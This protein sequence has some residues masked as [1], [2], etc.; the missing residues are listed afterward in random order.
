MP[1]IKISILLLYRSLFPSHKFRM[2][3]NILAAI[4]VAWGIA[5]F[6]VAV[7]TCSPISGF[8]DYTIQATCINPQAFYIANSV[9]NVLVDIV[10]L[11]LPVHQ[12]VRLKLDQTQK[13][14]VCCMFLLG[15]L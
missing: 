9:P 15:G 1:L 5:V 10:M 7:F 6:F 12:V 8:W 3:T 11:C 2:A 4:V 14:G 13:V